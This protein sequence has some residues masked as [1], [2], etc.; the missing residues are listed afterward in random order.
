MTAIIISAAL[1]TGI[2]AALVPHIPKD[3]IERHI[4]MELPPDDLRF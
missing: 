3:W 4:A 1:I 2:A